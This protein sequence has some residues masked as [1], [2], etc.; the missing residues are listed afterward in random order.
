MQCSYFV[1]ANLV[2]MMLYIYDE[3]VIIALSLIFTCV[4]SF[5]SL[6]T[7]FLYIL[8]VIFY[9]NFTLRCCDDFFK[10]VSEINFVKVFFL[11]SFLRV[12]VRIDFIVFNK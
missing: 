9:F 3:V 4:V 6:C 1:T 12:C 5:L 8:Y 7:C 11:Q 10:S 2:L